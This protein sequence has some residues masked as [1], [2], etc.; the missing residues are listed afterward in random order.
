[1]TSH[2]YNVINISL[3][4]VKRRKHRLLSLLLAITVCTSV[5][6]QFV[7]NRR[8]AIVKKKKMNK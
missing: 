3:T 1:M 4:H 2:H 5:Q 6:N 8:H 7:Q